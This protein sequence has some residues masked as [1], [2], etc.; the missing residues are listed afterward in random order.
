MQANAMFYKVVPQRA[1]GFN[2]LCGFNPKLVFATAERITSAAD[3]LTQE[4]AE[5][6]ARKHAADLNAADVLDRTSG[7]V[8]KK[9]VKNQEKQVPANF[10]GMGIGYYEDDESHMNYVEVYG[11]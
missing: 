11:M 2:V 6:I 4:Q 1:G 3:T 7:S 8:W 5:E 9:I 10:V